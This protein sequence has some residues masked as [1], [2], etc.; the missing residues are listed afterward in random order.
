LREG[1]RQSAGSA[2]RDGDGERVRKFAVSI[3]LGFGGSQMDGRAS[4][5]A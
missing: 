2:I 3:G 5:D 4:R 1:S